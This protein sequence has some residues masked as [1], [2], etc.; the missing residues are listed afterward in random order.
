MQSRRF[1][2]ILSGAL[3]IFFLLFTR[4]YNI[5]WGLPLPFHPDERNMVSAVQKLHCSSG[6]WENCLDPQFYAYGQFPL[7]LAYGLVQLKHL[8][9]GSFGQP[10]TYEEGATA[11]R[12]ISAFSSVLTV[13]AAL[14][15]VKSIRKR[16]ATPIFFLTLPLIFS[17]A[18]IQFSHFGTTES[19]LMCLYT[20]LIASGIGLLEKKWDTRMFVFLSS[21]L[22]GLAVGTKISS[23]IF[24]AVPASALVLT[25][26]KEKEHR[27]LNFSGMLFQLLFLT[28]C[29]A[30]LASPHNVIHFEDFKSALAFESGVAQGA[31]TVFYTRQFFLS[32]PIVF[33][34]IKVFPYALGIP[35]FLLFLLSLFLPKDRTFFFLKVSFIV[36][37][38]PTAFLYT[39]W[40]R[41]MAPVFPL[42]IILALLF[43]L[44]V[45]KR[46]PLFYTLLI[47]MSLPGLFF[48]SIYQAKDVRLTAS[49]WIYENVPNNA[50]ILSETANVVDI[51]VSTTVQDKRFTVTSFDF[52]EV[53]ANPNLQ[54]KLEEEL[55]KAD[56]ILVPSRRVFAN[57][58]CYGMDISFSHERCLKLREKY[59][60]L[61]AYYEKLFDG[62]LGFTEVSRFQSFPRLEVFGK[63]ILEFSD[64]SAEE[65]WTVFDHP[66]V[67]I[68]KRT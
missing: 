10:V 8:T 52:Y 36:Y 62:S 28:F 9:W 40:S 50:H 60:I 59:P 54:E 51:P 53:D 65:T 29:I 33:Q 19:L 67:R 35:T 57:H 23:L 16:K 34:F 39:K 31:Y 43:L 6:S 2:I 24:L 27:L 25:Y 37:F 63:K 61:T 56:Y 1:L 7:Y 68:Y 22:T 47:L 5:Q 45:V 14:F 42:M 41:F 4:L 15:I 3:F 12:T 13:L 44:E 66:V 30:V 18:L 64:E 46:K 26:L 32:L 21:L 38:L 11:L 49:D 48:F 55:A 58:T 17:P 20:L